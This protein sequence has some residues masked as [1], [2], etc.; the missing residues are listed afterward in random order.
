MQEI[1][2]KRGCIVSGRNIDDNRVA[3]IILD[4]FRNCKLGNITLEKVDD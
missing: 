4:D 3:N 2:K 1:G